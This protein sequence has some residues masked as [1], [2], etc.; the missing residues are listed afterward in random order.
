MYDVLPSVFSTQ[1]FTGTPSVAAIVP[2]AQV[3]SK[4]NPTY[5]QPVLTK[6]V[7][8]DSVGNNDGDAVGTCVGT[9][10]LWQAYWMDSVG[11]D[12]SAAQEVFKSTWLTTVPEQLVPL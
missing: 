5:T 7:F 12:V 2:V 3:V 6:L 11:L 4:N 9:V 10:P 1:V 8:G